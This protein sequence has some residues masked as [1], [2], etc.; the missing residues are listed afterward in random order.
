[1]SNRPLVAVLLLALA[2]ACQSGPPRFTESDRAAI[3]SLEQSFAKLA[4]AGGYTTLVDLYYT[5]DAL[6]L[7]PNAPPA[8]GRAAIEATFRALPPLAAFT[9]VANDIEGAGDLAYSYGT[10][11]MT[12]NVPGAPAPVSDEGSS[13]VIYKRQ[14]GGAWKAWRDMFHSSLPAMGAAPA[15]PRK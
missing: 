8:V 13:L 7:A 12:L 5:E 6:L 11:T 2:S 1:M 9:L 4:V 15:E 10:Y 14:P 3:V